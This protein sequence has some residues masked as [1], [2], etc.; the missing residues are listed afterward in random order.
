MA[1][2]GL[3]IKREYREARGDTGSV[4]LLGLSVTSM[5]KKYM[6][7]HPS[8]II[9]RTFCKCPTTSGK[10]IITLHYNPK[11]NLLLFIPNNR[12]IFDWPYNRK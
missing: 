4:K 1:S 11:F 12:R 6:S 8:Y 3:Q 9:Y 5:K 10:R 2:R 7:S